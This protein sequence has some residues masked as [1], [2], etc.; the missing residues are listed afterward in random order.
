MITS[1]IGMPELV[2]KEPA[3]I[4]VGVAAALLPHLQSGSPIVRT[5]RGSPELVEAPS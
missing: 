3:V 5:R 2:G 4:A 1:P